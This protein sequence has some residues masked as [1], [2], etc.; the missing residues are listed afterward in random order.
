MSRYND[1]S[2]VVITTKYFD[3]SPSVEVAHI[4][5]ICERTQFQHPT[6]NSLVSFPF[7][8]FKDSHVGVVAERDS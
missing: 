1:S 4:S 6:L 7:H 8:K 2:A 3:K 5:N